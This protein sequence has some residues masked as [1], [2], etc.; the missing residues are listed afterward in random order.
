M[1]AD[2]GRYWAAYQ[3]TGD[4]WQ[5]SQ[6]AE[7]QGRVCGY[8]LPLQVLDKKMNNL[9]SGINDLINF[10]HANLLERSRQKGHIYAPAALWF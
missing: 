10:W 5:R 3:A 9:E 7:P 6:R 8:L 4:I 2:P 1:G